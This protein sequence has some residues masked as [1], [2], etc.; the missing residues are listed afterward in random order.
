M[1][2]GKEDHVVHYVGKVT[3]EV[4]CRREIFYYRKTDAP[5]GIQYEDIFAFKTN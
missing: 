3:G 4:D 2:A 5:A 1:G